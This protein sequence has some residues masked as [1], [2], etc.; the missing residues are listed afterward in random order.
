M[1]VK[2][3]YVGCSET[4]NDILKDSLCNEHEFSLGYL[5]YMSC[6]VPRHKKAGRDSSDIIWI[7]HWY[8]KWIK[9]MTKKAWHY[10][11]AFMNTI[12][13][14]NVKIAKAILRPLK[15]ISWSQTLLIHY[16]N[17]GTSNINVVVCGWPSSLWMN[18]LN[19]TYQ[20]SQSNSDKR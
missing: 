4:M 19:V 18:K 9:I 8:P 16:E 5:C 17:N 13:P 10:M 3:R 20:S 6:Y 7:S 11:S 15:M 2:P 14:G 12:P 1:E